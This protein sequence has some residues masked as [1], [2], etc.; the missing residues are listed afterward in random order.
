MSRFNRKEKFVVN[1]LFTFPQL[2]IKKGS[3]DSSQ[4]HTA[5]AKKM[6]KKCAALAKFFTFG[7][8][9]YHRLHDILDS[10]VISPVMQWPMFQS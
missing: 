5:T 4:S 2:E 10:L 7:D 6:Y 8:S 1:I 9:C 3:F